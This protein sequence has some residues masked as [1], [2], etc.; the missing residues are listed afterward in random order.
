[1]SGKPVAAKKATA[2]ASGAAKPA[3]AATKKAPAKASVP[4]KAAKAENPLFPKRTKNLR[5]GGAVRPTGRDLTRFVKWPRYVSAPLQRVSAP[6]PSRFI[7]QSARA[8]CRVACASRRPL[9]HRVSAL[10]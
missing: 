6:A 7:A 10:A 8:L 1:M 4:V 2:G 5:V 3:A 9:P